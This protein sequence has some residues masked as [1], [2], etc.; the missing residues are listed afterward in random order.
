MREN[1]TCGFSQI[2]KIYIKQ[3]GFLSILVASVAKSTLCG[4]KI[5][6]LKSVKMQKMLCDGV[7]VK[8][9]D[10]INYKKT[11]TIVQKHIILYLFLSA[12]TA[13]C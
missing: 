8:S 7:S 4:D 12:F 3:V 1:F 13:G 9:K 11:Y 10:C 2:N 6:T 5:G